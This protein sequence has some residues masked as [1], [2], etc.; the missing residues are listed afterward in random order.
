MFFQF[1]KKGVREDNDRLVSRTSGPGKIM[2]KNI[3]GTTERHSKKNAVLRHSQ[4]GFKKGRSCLT[5]FYPSRV[6]SPAQ[7]MK[8]RLHPKCMLVLLD[9]N[10]V[11][12]T[13][14]TTSFWTSCP[15]V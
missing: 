2:E 7:R 1:T 15:T 14:R 13:I 8:G 12:D 3:L 11:F 6:R 10:K 4:H 5:N 9:F